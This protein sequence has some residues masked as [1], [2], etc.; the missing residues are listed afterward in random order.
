MCLECS[1]VLDSHREVR[2]DDVMAQV[3][4]TYMLSLYSM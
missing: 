4:P 1:L 2:S 3:H